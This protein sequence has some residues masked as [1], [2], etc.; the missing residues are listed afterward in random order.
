MFFPPSEQFNAIDEWRLGKEIKHPTADCCTLG[1][2]E[3]RSS[4]NSVL[5]RRHENR[6]DRLDATPILVASEEERD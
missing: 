4:P 2:V 1:V 5:H 3:S 6:P